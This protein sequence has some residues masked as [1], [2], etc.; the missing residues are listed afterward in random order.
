MESVIKLASRGISGILPIRAIVLDVK[1]CR[2][3]ELESFAGRLVLKSGRFSY[4]LEKN[5][6]ACNLFTSK[7]I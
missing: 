3:R 6:D 1:I 4:R 7:L 2:K 5:T